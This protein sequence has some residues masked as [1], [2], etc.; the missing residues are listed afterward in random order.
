MSLAAIMSRAPITVGEQETVADA[1]AKLVSNRLVN[2]PVV[3]SQERY[4]GSFGLID[5]FSLLVPRVALAGDL[6]SNL[7]FANKSEQLKRKYQDVRNRP[8]SEVVN[9]NAPTLDPKFSEGEALRL[10]C[11]NHN[12]LPVVDRES[13]RLLGLVSCWDALRDI[14]GAP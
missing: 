10:F 4:V 8:L 2:L 6:A 11:R 14:A 13:G 5:L 3:D 12:S 7:R 1:T 9:R